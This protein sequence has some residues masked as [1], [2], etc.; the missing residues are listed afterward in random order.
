MREKYIKNKKMIKSYLGLGTTVCALG[1]FWLLS[2]NYIFG[3]VFLF[4]GIIFLLLSMK[5]KKVTVEIENKM[6]EKC[7]NCNDDVIHEIKYKYFVSSALSTEEEFNKKTNDKMKYEIHYYKCLK[8]KICM[9]IV[10][11]YLYTDNK[12]KPL[13]DKISIDFN[14]NNEY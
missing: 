12:E 9:T 6:L 5:A 10:K 14:Y 13:N 8:C 1:L 4:L 3:I 7:I 2:N 11:Q